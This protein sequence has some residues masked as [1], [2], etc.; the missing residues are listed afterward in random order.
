MKTNHQK[1]KQTHKPNVF[2]SG[3]PAKGNLSFIFLKRTEAVSAA[4][5]HSNLLS[6][7]FCGFLNAAAVARENKALL[8]GSPS[9]SYLRD[10]WS[11]RCTQSQKDLLACTPRC[12]DALMKNLEVPV[13]LRKRNLTS[14]VHFPSLK[15][16]CSKRGFSP[17]TYQRCSIISMLQSQ[18][19][20]RIFRLLSYEEVVWV[21]FKCICSSLSPVN[22]I[23]ASNHSKTMKGTNIP[24]FSGPLQPKSYE[25]ASWCFHCCSPIPEYNCIS[26]LL[27]LPLFS[28]PESNYSVK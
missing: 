25:T 18:S 9:T 15:K 20:R 4:W 27:T 13:S 11:P 3:N 19:M 8:N 24:G 1:T 16:I 5:Q 10:T 14:S 6:Q 26:G 2:I 23:K 22:Y 12:R 17:V 28:L 21:H 7:H